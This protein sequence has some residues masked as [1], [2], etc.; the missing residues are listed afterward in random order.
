MNTQTFNFKHS[1]RSFD[2]VQAAKHA[3]RRGRTPLEAHRFALRVDHAQKQG[4]F[5]ILGEHADGT[6]RTVTLRLTLTQARA[7]A[8]ATRRA[9]Y[10]L[11]EQGAHYSNSNEV[12]MLSQWF[13]EDLEDHLEAHVT[14]AQ[15]EAFA[16][17]TRD[18]LPPRM[19]A[20][21]QATR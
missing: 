13:A 5:A 7:L 1:G 3:L 8:A 9:M 14:P 21:L 11:I 17:L 2:Y 19:Q 18:G 6:D 12:R 4:L 15:A 10:R 20:A 16:A